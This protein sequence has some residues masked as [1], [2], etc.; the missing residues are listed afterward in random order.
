MNTTTWNAYKFAL[1]VSIG[2]FVFGLDAAIISG[3]IRYI[4]SEFSLSDLEIGMVV[5]A[6]SLGAIIALF[7]AGK[8]A[9]VLGRKKTLIIIALLYVVSAIA[10]ALATNFIM[11]TAARFLGGLAFISLSL[12]SMYIGE[13]APP[14]IRGKLVAANQLNIVVGL[15]AAYFINY[16]LVM[17]VS[18]SS[19]LFSTQN[20]WRTMLGSEIIPAL[21]WTVLLFRV[22][23]SPRWLMLKGKKEEALRVINLISEPEE[24]KKIVDETEAYLKSD[25]SDLSIMHQLKNLFSSRM[26]TIFIIGFSIAMIQGVTGMNAIL[27]YAPTVFEQLGSG[28]NAS[29][30]QAIYIGITSV[31]FTSIAIVLIDRLGRRPLLIF[32][33][34]AVVVSHTT[35]WYGFQDATYQLDQA[36]VAKIAEYVDIEPLAP[37]IGQTFESDIEFKN[38]LSS[39][40]DSNT[41]RLAQGHIIEAAISVNALMILIGILAFIAAFNI[42]IGPIMWVLFSEIFPNSV[43]TIAIPF[44]A[45]ITSTSSYFIQQFFPWQL[46]NFGAAN[47]FLIYAGFGALGLVVLYKFLPETKGQSIEDLEHTLVG[48]QPLKGPSDTPVAVQK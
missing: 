48:T 45:L 1:I 46:A 47:T 29:F 6:P 4:A 33:L 26:R 32:G 39:I 38:M 36:S 35:C 37:Y 25:D 18:E 3:T 13:I 41:L 27:F 40:Y 42:S 19:V 43:R 16:Y 10:S 34:I 7:I 22:P 9:D 17:N 31:V 11:L 8:A 24:G 23:E 12:A 5:G 2:G 30:L 21:I 28:V 20:V 15:S 44:F 14:K